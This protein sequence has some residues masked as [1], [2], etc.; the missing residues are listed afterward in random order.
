MAAS[1]LLPLLCEY[2]IRSTPAAVAIRHVPRQTGGS[3]RLTA[4]PAN[5]WHIVNRLF[6]SVSVLRSA[7]M[8]K[9][10]LCDFCH[11]MGQVVRH[12]LSDGTGEGRQW[13]GRVVGKGKP[14]CC[15]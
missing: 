12:V 3:P 6:S 14:E 2:K 9:V 13:D 4:D 7:G 10:A 5:V 1:D 11:S 15:R 8:L